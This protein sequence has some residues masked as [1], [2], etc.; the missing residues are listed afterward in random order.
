[1]IVIDSYIHPRTIVRLLQH[2]KT[3]SGEISRNSDYWFYLRPSYGAVAAAVAD[4]TAG[5]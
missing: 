2:Y 5:S 1:M 4:S 3:G